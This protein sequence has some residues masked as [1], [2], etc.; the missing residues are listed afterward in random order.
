LSNKNFIS[1]KK[2]KERKKKE[3]KRKKKKNNICSNHW[4]PSGVEWTLRR[5]DVYGY[6]LIEII[7]MIEKELGMQKYKKVHLS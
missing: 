1:H 4:H 5:K 7:T 6:T 2:K 3:R